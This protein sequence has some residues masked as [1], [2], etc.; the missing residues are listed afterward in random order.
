MSVCYAMVATRRTLKLRAFVTISLAAAAFC[1]GCDSQLPKEPAPVST[2]AQDNL[3]VSWLG[4]GD[5]FF[6]TPFPADTRLVDGRVSLKGFEGSASAAL[7]KG[8]VKALDGVATGFS[9]TAG[10]F[11]RAKLDPQLNCGADVLLTAT[12]AEHGEAKVPLQCDFHSDAGPFGGANLFAI[13]PQQGD[14]LRPLTTYKVRAGGETLTTFT[15]WDPLQPMRQAVKALHA[16]PLPEPVTAFSLLQVYPHFCVY[17]S[18]TSMAVLQQGKPPYAGTGG[19]IDY[20]NPNVTSHQQARIFITIPRQ[21]MPAEG[22]PTAVFVRT[23]GGGDRPLI[24]RGV[25]DEKGVVATPGSGPAM[26]FAEAGMAGVQIDGPLGGLRNPSGA[27]EQLLIFNFSNLDAMRGNLVQSAAELTLLPKMLASLQLST[28]D[29]PGAV[30]PAGTSRFDSDHLAL[31]GHSMGATIAPLTIAFAP[32]YKVLILSGAGGSW[33]ENIMHKQLPMVVKP[34]AEALVGYAQIDR[35]LHRFD[36]VLSLVQWVGEVADP[37]VFARAVTDGWVAAKPPHILMIQGIVDRYIMPTIANA[38]SMAYRLDLGGQ[39]LDADHPET[40]GFAHAADVLKS[41]GGEQV[42]LPI[43]GN[44]DAGARTAVLVQHAE[45]GVEDGHEVAFQVTAAK[46][47]YQ[48]FLKTWLQNKT[49]TVIS[50]KGA[51]P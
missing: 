48:C 39:A 5:G 1:W 46:N 50:A 9:T 21:T 22:W 45:D 26:M 2:G 47:Q 43:T 33:I 3:P 32:Q 23:G 35:E 7:V 42:Q 14:P 34:L 6:A 51:C 38:T 36:P 12:A 40:K 15:T 16:L 41:V 49:P 25:R 30:A 31:M 19:G 24:D 4:D 13:L 27:D 20:A 29:C 10:I 11:A 17:R 8:A 18:R 28:S 44:R 37:P